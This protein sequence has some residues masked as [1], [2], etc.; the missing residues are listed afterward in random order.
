MTDLEFS[1]YICVKLLNSGEDCCSICAFQQSLLKN[2]DAASDDDEKLVCEN[3]K[4]DVLDDD[5]CYE[6]IRA[7]YEQH[8]EAH[9]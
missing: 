3:M 7:F 9:A 4:R 8:E 6:G 5:I 1:K 2:S